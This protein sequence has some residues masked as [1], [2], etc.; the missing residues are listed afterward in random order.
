MKAG[1][2]FFVILVLPFY[3][4]LFTF[5]L[6]VLAKSS[7]HNPYFVLSQSAWVTAGG[8]GSRIGLG[9]HDRLAIPLA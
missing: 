8:A 9:P 5:V 7:L 4:L 1:K 2:R 3:F 6:Y